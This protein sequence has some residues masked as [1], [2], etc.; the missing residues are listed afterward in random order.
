MRVP[1][2]PLSLVLFPGQTLPLHIVEERY[3]QMLQRC[4]RDRIPFGLVLIREGGRLGRGAPHDV[5]ALA[6]V[7]QVDEIPEGN[8]TVP[9]PHRGSC[10]HIVCRGGERF[11]V[12]DTDRREAEYLM[13]D[14]ELFPDEPAPPPALLMVSERVAA[15]F[16]EYYRN[17]I[18]L[19]GGWQ[20][21]A[22][23]GQRTLLFDM[24]ALMTSQLQQ[25]E[26]GEGRL[27]TVAVPSLPNDPVALANVVAV[28]LNVQPSVKQ[29]LLETPSAL[30]RLQREAEIMAEET[31]QLEERLKLQYRRLFAQF[32]RSS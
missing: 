2:F 3:K 14:I 19:M 31:P 18:A 22:P 29:D 9:A 20:R 6:Y 26:A 32:G 8:C 30:A 11:R 23:P 17:V 27:R 10:F 25:S 7:T 4:L 15:L 24:Y 12:L 16:D 1:L 28:E 5:G 21:E 13:A